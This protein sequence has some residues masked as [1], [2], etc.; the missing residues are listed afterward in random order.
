MA[1]EAAGDSPSAAFE[2]WWDGREARISGI[3]K[4]G[5][6]KGLLYAGALQSIDDKGYWF[7]AVAGSSA[8]AITATLIAAGFTVDELAAAVPEAMRTV[9]KMWLG[10]L[11]GSPIIRTGKLQRWL[12]QSL[13]GKVTKFGVPSAE[14]HD[15]VTFDQLH[16]ATG[17]EL[18]V[19]A[20]DVA[21]R[22]PT[23]FSAFTTPD[24]PVAPAVMASSAIPLAFRPGRL[25]RRFPDGTTQVHRLMDGG[26]WANYPAFVFKDRSFREHHH[27]PEPPSDGITIGFTLDTGVEADEGEADGFAERTTPAYRDRGAALGGFLRI[28]PLRIYLMTIVPLVVALQAIYTMNHGGLTMLKDYATRDGVPVFITGLAGFFDGFFTHFTPALWIV[29][30]ALIVIALLLAVIGATLVDSGIPAMRTLMA[31]GTDVPY[32]V[33]TTD[34]DNVVRLRVPPGVNTMSFRLSAETVAA[35]IQAAR[36]EADG[37]LDEIFSIASPAT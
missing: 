1:D 23:V 9:K 24:V 4:G 13:H 22:Q 3:F 2:R 30:G 28:A 16:T 25:R 18:Y 35:A 32:W 8:G 33:G 29:L 5:G 21:L 26:V 12:E 37:Q 11:V 19:V 27:L 7:R 10:D 15:Q 31:V 36:R 34:G 20:V 17:I 6:A 14:G